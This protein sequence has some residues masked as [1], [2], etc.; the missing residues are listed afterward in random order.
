MVVGG[1]SGTL[2]TVLKALTEEPPLPVVVIVGS[3]RAADL[4]AYAYKEIED[5]DAYND[6]E[7]PEG[8][9]SKAEELFRK[10]EKEERNTYCKKVLGCMKKKD[11]VS[12]HKTKLYFLLLKY[13]PQ[14]FQF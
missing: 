6:S 13:F 5:I 4:L 1:G 12:K 11:Y 14:T 2:N 10:S 8:L 3:G 7:C 9:L